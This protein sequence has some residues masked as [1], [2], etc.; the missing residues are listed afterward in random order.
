MSP[1]SINNLPLRG[2]SSTTF[3]GGNNSNSS[4]N[5]RSGMHINRDS[6]NTNQRKTSSFLTPN[7]AFSSNNSSF[8]G[9]GSQ[10]K[11]NYYPHTQG[12]NTQQITPTN[13]NNEAITFA[14]MQNEI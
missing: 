6:Y 2:N 9:G 12:F 4:Y 10:S 3:G 11:Q 13:L 8:L 14:K 7:A 1:S 5:G